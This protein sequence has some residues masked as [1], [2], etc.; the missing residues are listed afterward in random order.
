MRLGMPCTF[1]TVKHRGERRLQ[2]TNINKHA[3]HQ[4]SLDWLGS[5]SRS[6]VSS[7]CKNTEHD[8]EPETKDREKRPPTSSIP[9]S[10]D[11]DDGDGIVNEVDLPAFDLSFLANFN[12]EQSEHGPEES[13][14][15]ALFS[16]IFPSTP[17]ES[18]RIS[19]T[20][21]SDTS[22][23]IPLLS[24]DE[25]RRWFSPVSQDPSFFDIRLTMSAPTAFPSGPSSQICGC[26]AAV[27]FAVE[28]LEASCHAGQRAELDSIIAFQKEA[29]KRCRAQ[30]ECSSC[31][32][33][34]EALV[35]LVFMLE[36]IVAACG[37]M[38]GLYRVENVQ[39]HLP[40]SS[41]LPVSSPDL[42]LAPAPMA[43]CPISLPDWRELFLGDYEINSPMEWEHLVRVLIFLQLRAVMELLADVQSM[44]S[45]VLGK[46]LTASLAQA[47]LRLGEL[48]KDVYLL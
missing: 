14:S 24:E 2:K 20:E 30:L 26:L 1:N 33:K 47:G 18:E 34:R 41:S 15:S 4:N 44:K 29:I 6:S 3:S 8:K 11:S 48:E 46:T 37:R 13:S 38:V 39:P 23:P 35:L 28:R 31:I 9:K 22:F 12:H 36:K 5:P 21:M 16:A 19:I 7:N 10:V 27:T 32:S 40:S 45:A 17:H 42:G 43:D 25:P